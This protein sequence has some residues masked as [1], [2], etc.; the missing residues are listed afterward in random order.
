VTGDLR[1]HGDGLADHAG[2]FSSGTSKSTDRRPD[3]PLTKGNGNA[4]ADRIE[5][6]LIR[7]HH[8]TTRTAGQIRRRVCGTVLEHRRPR[9]GSLPAP[10]TRSS[11]W[12]NERKITHITCRCGRCGYGCSSRRPSSAFRIPYRRLA[13][14]LPLLVARA[15]NSYTVRGRENAHATRPAQAAHRRLREARHYFRTGRCGT[16]RPGLRCGRRHARGVADRCGRAWPVRAVPPKR[17]R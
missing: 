13:K 3:H 12:R 6:R 16:G 10:A 8:R 11:G 17:L 4:Q 15:V 1:C 7:R 5:P 9:T 14:R 2:R